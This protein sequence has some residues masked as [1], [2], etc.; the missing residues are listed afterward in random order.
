MEDSIA[1]YLWDYLRRSGASGFMLPLSGGM[2][3]GATA[4]SVF[5]LANKIYKS[6]MTEDKDYE[7]HK[8]ILA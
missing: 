3:S 4:I 6:I 1:C 8:K 5:Y 2:D 7:T